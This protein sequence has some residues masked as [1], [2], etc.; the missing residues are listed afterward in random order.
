MVIPAVGRQNEEFS[1]GQGSEE[2]RH[3][4]LR[5]GRAAAGLAVGAA[6]MV[7]LGLSV[8]AAI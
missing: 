4:R 5:R 8:G 6:T 7:I 1:F 2:R 3:V